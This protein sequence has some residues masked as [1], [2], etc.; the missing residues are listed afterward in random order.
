MQS[1]AALFAS[2]ARV[3]VAP[4]VDMTTSDA[5]G[6]EEKCFSVFPDRVVDAFVVA[7]PRRRCAVARRVFNGLESKP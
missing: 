5:D 4:R 7:N 3:V 2:T 6:C 1:R